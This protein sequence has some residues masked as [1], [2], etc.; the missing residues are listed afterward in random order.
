MIRKLKLLILFLTIGFSITNLIGCYTNDEFK[1]DRIANSDG[2]NGVTEVE[3]ALIDTVKTHQLFN[4]DIPFDDYKS[5]FDAYYMTPSN[6]KQLKAYEL[7][8]K[9]VDEQLLLS[10]HFIDLSIN[11][12]RKKLTSIG[13]DLDYIDKLNNS[14]GYPNYKIYVS[15]VIDG[16]TEEESMLYILHVIDRV[17]IDYP[18]SF[19]DNFYEFT[20]YQLMRYKFEKVDGSQKIFTK[21]RIYGFRYFKVEEVNSENLETQLS[22]FENRYFLNGDPNYI[23]E[24]DLNDLVK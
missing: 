19:S 13:V 3:I 7:S 17:D 14:N 20:D 22:E 1:V 5:V 16:Y 11:E 8:F 18:E 10:E 9:D 24:L 6:L 4:F 23:M 12:S 2:L 15:E 21:T